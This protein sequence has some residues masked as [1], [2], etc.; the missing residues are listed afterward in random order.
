MS[1]LR[2]NIV[3][4]KDANGPFEA[5]EGI[6][7]AAS[8]NIKFQTG[9]SL[10]DSNNN[11]YLKFSAVVSG[12]VNEITISNAI[13]AGT[14][15][16]S[17]TGNDTNI[18]LDLISKGSGT[19]KANGDT[20]VTLNSSQ[21]LNGKTLSAPIINTATINNST[22]INPT[23]SGVSIVTTNGVETLTNKT[24]TSPIISTISN[25]GVLTLPTSTDTLV[26]RATTDTLTNKTLT[27]PKIDVIRDTGNSNSMTINSTDVS[28]STAIKP[29]AG[30]TSVA[31]VLFTSGT[32]L[33]TQTAGAVEYAN[34]NYFFGLDAS[35]GR[36]W[37]QAVH[38]ARLNSART[39]TANT[40]LEAIFP[41]GDRSLALAANTLYYFKAYFDITTVSNGVNAHQAQFSFAFSNTQQN[42]Y[43][44]YML[45]EGAAATTTQTSAI[46]DVTTGSPTITVG[47]SS[48]AAKNILIEF[49]GW[50]SSNL[51]IGG[52]FTPQFAQTI[53]GATSA[54]KNCWIMVQPF[55]LQTTTK[56][57]NWS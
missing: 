37:G 47:T 55:G 36:A 28:F 41:V 12:A 8:K 9:S 48:I 32:L 46:I 54:N 10:A 53:N 3:V 1:R 4:N 43:Y 44:R 22:L 39:K 19:V 25:A 34:P 21:T 14:P 42:M 7:V 17:A 13:A 20:I 51:L 35:S 30:S 26:G 6:N 24:L 16:I 31:P 11:E 50:F 57:G 18:S 56:V 45:Q 33:T 38:I 52:T 2:A 5:G 15:S 27:T 49:E 40:T 29:F 23:F